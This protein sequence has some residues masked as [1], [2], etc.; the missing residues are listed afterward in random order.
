MA[1]MMMLRK[2]L[3]GHVEDHIYIK[4]ILRSKS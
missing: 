4:K 1:Y 2:E 3:I